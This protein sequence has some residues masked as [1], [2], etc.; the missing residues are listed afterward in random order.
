MTVNVVPSRFFFSF[1]AFLIIYIIV[2]YKQLYEV[3]YPET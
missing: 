3:L 1:V 2:S